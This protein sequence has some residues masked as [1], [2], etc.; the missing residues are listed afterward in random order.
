MHKVPLLK[1]VITIFQN[2]TS[3]WRLVV[4]HIKYLIVMFAV[5]SMRVIFASKVGFHGHQPPLIQGTQEDVKAYYNLRNE[6]KRDENLNIFISSRNF[7]FANH[8]HISISQLQI[9]IFKITSIFPFRKLQ[10]SKWK[11][12]NDLQ[13]RNL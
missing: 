9:S 13:S 7:Y 12:A 8:K 10:I 2:F 4:P 1:F 3:S 11:Y 6:T 5:I